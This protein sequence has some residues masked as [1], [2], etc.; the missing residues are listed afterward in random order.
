MDWFFHRR[1]PTGRRILH[2]TVLRDGSSKDMCTAD[3]V[4]QFGREGP[5]DLYS[6]Y[7]FGCRRFR[8]S[9]CLPSV[10]RLRK[11]LSLSLLFVTS[12]FLL[13]SPSTT[14]G[15]YRLCDGVPVVLH[16]HEYLGPLFTP[17]SRV[18]RTDPP[19]SV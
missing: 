7:L 17:K 11:F 6:I 9:L 2:Q 18:L 19:G 3:L 10:I 12:V 5:S 4:G 8:L 15:V 13:I 16:W 14:Q 1:C